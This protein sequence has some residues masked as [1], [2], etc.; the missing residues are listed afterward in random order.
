MPL[1]IPYNK[2][3]IITRYLTVLLHSLTFTPP[4]RSGNPGLFTLLPRVRNA[5]RERCKL[6]AAQQLE[7][8]TILDWKSKPQSK[9][10]P[11][12]PPEDRRNNEAPTSCGRGE[13][14]A[15]VSCPA[16][17]WELLGAAGSCWELLG[18]AERL[19]MQQAGR[20]AG[21]WKQQSWGWLWLWFWLLQMSCQ[22]A[23]G[24]RE[25]SASVL[26]SWGSKSKYFTDV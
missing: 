17:G 26:R 5:H 16:V 21:L 11:P 8:S 3:I 23:A 10:Q 24:R 2:K 13:A 15:A 4:L 9:R 14:R 22:A 12:S 25:T 20:E 1:K 18:A 6:R 7:C 19:R